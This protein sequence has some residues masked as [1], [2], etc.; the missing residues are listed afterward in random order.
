M[1]ASGPDSPGQR[2]PELKTAAAL[3]IGNELLNG[4]VQDTNTRFLASRLY[5]RGVKLMRV[6]I[7]PDDYDE[8]AE[9]VTRLSAK[10]DY[11]FTSGGIGPTLDDITYE[12]IA[13]AFGLQLKLNEFTVSEMRRISPQHEIN[14]ARK[15]MALF[16][17]PCELYST[18]GLW[19]PI[20]CVN[21]NVFI[22]PGVPWIFERML[23]FNLHRFGS[24]ETALKSSTVYTNRYEG[25][26][27]SE[28]QRIADAF[29]LLDF[30]SY[31]RTQPDD[32]YNVMLT[33]EGADGELVRAAAAAL[34][35]AVQ[36][37]ATPDAL[38]ARTGMVGDTDRTPPA[39]D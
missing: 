37:A 21:T 30:G 3:I 20:V 38:Q 25:E 24:D 12:A 19:V 4:K 14:E 26:L 5:D 27:A 23:Q 32:K 29:P 15:R 16:P 8:I 39:T 28:L 31:P 2:N 35:A 13:R 1:S 33:I 10:S 17:D 6:E 7:I 11:V 34:S 9:A 18:D 36:G 22:L